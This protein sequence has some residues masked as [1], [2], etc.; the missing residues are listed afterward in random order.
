MLA[1]IWQG[2][3]L[4]KGAVRQC[5]RLAREGRAVALVVPDEAARAA[6]GPNLLD[7]S[8]RAP[9]AQAGYAQAEPP[10]RA[11]SPPYGPATSSRTAL[12]SDTPPAWDEACGNPR[13]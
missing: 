12:V 13:R 10:R 3:G 7:S 5:R 6:I 1:P 4:M 2:F 11:R 9:A 8:R